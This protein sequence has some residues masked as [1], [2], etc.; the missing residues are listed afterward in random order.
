MNSLDPVTQE[1]L[2]NAFAGISE[3]MA[4]VEYRASFSPIIREMLDYSCGVFDPLGRMVANSEQIPAQLGLMGFALAE[5]RRALGEDWDPGDTVICNHP[6]RGGTHTPDLQ[7]FTPIHCDGTLIGYAG[8]IA[9]H[10]DVG[11]RVPG[12]ESGDNTE[13]FQEGLLLPP[14][15]LYEGGS[16]SRALHEVIAANVRDPESTLGDLAAQVAACRRAQ[17]RFDAL[18]A[19][20]TVTDIGEA[21]RL[22]VDRTADRTKAELETWPA[23]RVVSEGFMDGDAYSPGTPLLIRAAIEVV[24]GALRVDLTGSSEQ[25]MGGIN[26]P[27]SS[28]HAAAYFAVRCFLDQS[29]PHNEGMARQIEVTAPEGTIVRPRPPAA[30]GARHLTVQRLADV[31][32]RGLGELKPER[33]VASSNVSFPNFVIQAVDPRTGRLTLLTDIVGGGGG[34]RQA[35][36]GDNAIDAYTSNCALLPTEVAE[37]EYPWRIRATRLVP[38]SGGA[39]RHTGGL[40]MCREYELLAEEADGMYEIEQT[41]ARFG[42]QGW[43]GGEPGAPAQ[44]AIRRAGSD[45]LEVLPGKGTVRLK[46]G[47]VLCVTSS[48]GGGFGTPAG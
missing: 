43:D 20:Y 5:A 44:I 27:W 32:C 36:A 10:I 38:E 29:I 14:V 11:G 39:G 24:G 37:L 21:M 47:D 16:P 31:L 40:A 30:V 35:A 8:S 13:V 26:V 48:G 22:L 33:A 42:A 6:Y 9:H 19:T 17:E 18:C 25:V 23:R 41:D 7:V 2:G 46:R 12:T 34:A 45:E 4:A 15:K 28:T 1:I 3:E